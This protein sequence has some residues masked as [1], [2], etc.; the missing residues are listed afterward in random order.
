ME[1]WNYGVSCQ[2][3]FVKLVHLVGFIIK[4]ICYDARS[5]ERKIRQCQTGKGNVSVKFHPGTSL[6]LS[7]NL[8]DIYHC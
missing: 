8:Y 3:Q 2:N 7:T 4:E 6:K 1:P 5:H